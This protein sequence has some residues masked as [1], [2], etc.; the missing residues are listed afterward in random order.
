MNVDA[1]TIERMVREV[2]RET[3]GTTPVR[4]NPAK[5]PKTE[6]KLLSIPAV[7]TPAA[8]P[9]PASTAVVI[10]E[11]IIT[12][13]L[14]KE[15]TQPGTKVVVSKRAIIT[16]AAQDY[17]RN[18]RITLERN[19]TSTGLPSGSNSVRWKIYLSSIADHTVRAIDVVCQQR[20][21]VTRELTGTASE[22]ANLAVSAV[23]RAEVAGVIVVTAAPELVACRAN[24][25]TII[26]AAVVSD[27]AGWSRMQLQ[28]KPN[29]VCISPQSRSFMEL[30]NLLVK[31]VTGPAPEAPSD[32]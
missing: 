15:Q 3:Q 5:T 24:R 4:D 10:G 8:E 19:E 22:A 23:S 12:A 14:L 25:N 27:L 17:L 6:S 30:Q 16:P 26:R 31:V 13:D 29:V 9:A 1:A 7:G 11:R 28:L 18:F 21:Q 20:N 2:L 32:W